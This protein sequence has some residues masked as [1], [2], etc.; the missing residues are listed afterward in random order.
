MNHDQIEGFVRAYLGTNPIVS[1]GTLTELLEEFQSKIVE[2]CYYSA[3]S[4]EFK[5]YYKLN[6][7]YNEGYIA[8]IRKA[9]E[10]VLVKKGGSN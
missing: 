3:L 2:Q 7:E 8:G 9:A 6:P 1:R 10:A 4:E 5:S